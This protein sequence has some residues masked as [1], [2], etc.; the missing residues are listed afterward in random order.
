MSYVS[1]LDTSKADTL[2]SGLHPLTI[3]VRFFT[4]IVSAAWHRLFVPD[5]HQLVVFSLS[6]WLAWYS[7]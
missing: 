3:E 1:T 4:S 5:Q 6:K 7:T 2:R